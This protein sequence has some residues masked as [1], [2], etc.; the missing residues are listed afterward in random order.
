MRARPPSASLGGMAVWTPLRSDRTSADRSEPRPPDET[1]PPI[2][3]RARAISRTAFS[4][5]LGLAALWVAS[6]FLPALTWAT[7]IAITTWPIYIRF[8]AL[9]HGGRSPALAALLFTLL[10]GVVLLV[11]II[12]TV[13][14][15]AQGSDAVVLR[16]GQL[17]EDGLSVPIW[18]VQLSIAC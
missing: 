16:L 5:L 15:I 11:P 18:V 12:L 10:I 6:D 1:A 17:R 14:Q 3:S 13:H 7:V 8:T 4:I 9:I 2:G